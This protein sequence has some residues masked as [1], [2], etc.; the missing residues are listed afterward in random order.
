[1]N[2]DYRA[3]GTKVFVEMTETEAVDHEAGHDL[4]EQGGVSLVNNERSKSQQGMVVAVGPGNKNKDGDMIEV[5][6]KV[7]DRVL[8]DR[9]GSTEI[10]LEDKRYRVVDDREI[11]AVI[12]DD[13]QKE[14]ASWN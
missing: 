4:R 12:E 14:D 9:M 7:G 2:S 8:L 1:M 13:Q 5:Y 11:L 6:A 10:F 3:T